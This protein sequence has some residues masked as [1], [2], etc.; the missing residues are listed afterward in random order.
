MS[1]PDKVRGITGS[2][3]GDEVIEPFLLTATAVIGQLSE[4]TAD[5]S[6]DTVTMATAYLAAHFLTTSPVGDGSKQVRRE[7]LDAKYMVEY[8]TP[9]NMGAGILGTQYGQTANL[10]LGGCL[11]QMD[12][13]S[14][15]IEVIGSIGDDA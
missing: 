8:L 15:S 4:C 10:L 1:C 3:L 6:A 7:S 2:T 5:L 12:K 9:F 14:P 13:F 11:A